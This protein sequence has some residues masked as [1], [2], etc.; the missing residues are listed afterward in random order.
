MNVH[1]WKE[2]SAIFHSSSLDCYSPNLAPGQ[3]AYI[4]HIVGVEICKVMRVK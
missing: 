1:R 4:A 2:I 3:F